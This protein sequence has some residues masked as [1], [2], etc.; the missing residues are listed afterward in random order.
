MAATDGHAKNC[1][2]FLQ[3]GDTYVMTPL[4]DILSLW[5]YFGKSPNQHNRRPGAGL[6]VYFDPRI[7]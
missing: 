7:A 5:P 2:I 3:P 1:S 4:Y 6:L